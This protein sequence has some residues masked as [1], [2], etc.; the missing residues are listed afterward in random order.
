MGV[1]G[2]NEHGVS[3]KGKAEE[4]HKNVQV[5]KPQEPTSLKQI[6]SKSCVDWLIYG[7]TSLCL[8]YPIVH[9]PPCSIQTIIKSMKNILISVSLMKVFE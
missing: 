4:Y 8:L 7:G 2:G 6:D 3:V 9:I 5:V 1:I